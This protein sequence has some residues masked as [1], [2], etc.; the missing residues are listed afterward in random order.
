MTSVQ[1]FLS[2]FEIESAW[3][4]RRSLSAGICR[5]SLEEGLEVEGLFG[6]LGNYPDEN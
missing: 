2:R 5:M 4:L 6:G 1:A 3:D